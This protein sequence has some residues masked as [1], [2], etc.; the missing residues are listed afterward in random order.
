[1]SVFKTFRTYKIYCLEKWSSDISDHNQDFLAR[2][3]ENMLISL[4]RVF[5][6]FNGPESYH[7]TFQDNNGSIE[8]DEFLMMMANRMK[9]NEKI[10]EVFEVFDTNDD[11]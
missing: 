11:G 9:A 1:M 2:A 3:L 5:E 6:N 10:R 8:L 7:K 4:P